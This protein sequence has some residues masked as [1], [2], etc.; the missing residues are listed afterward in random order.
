MEEP[1]NLKWQALIKLFKGISRFQDGAKEEYEQLIEMAKLDKVL[2]PRQV[3][4]IVDR[5]KYQI[6]LIENPSEIP[7][8]NMEKLENRNTYQLSNTESNGKQ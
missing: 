6:R 7:F 3:A 8:S 5:C 2:T 4:G 1:C